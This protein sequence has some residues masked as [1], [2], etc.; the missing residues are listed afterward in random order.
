MQGLIGVDGSKIILVKNMFKVFI[1][2]SHLG[3]AGLQTCSTILHKELVNQPIPFGV[4][5]I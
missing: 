1:I 2:T 4:F 3:P 5:A